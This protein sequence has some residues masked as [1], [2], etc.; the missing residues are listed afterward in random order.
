MMQLVIAR[1]GKVIFT[2][3]A[4]MADRERGVPLTDKTIM[5]MFSNTKMVVSVA[6]MI[7]VERA[8]LHLMVERIGVHQDRLAK[9]THTRLLAR[10]RRAKGGG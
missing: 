7:L 2:A 1:R 8:Q 6:A 10:E 9:H 3:S 5:R 4:G